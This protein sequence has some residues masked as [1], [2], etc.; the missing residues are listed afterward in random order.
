M[1]PNIAI[2]LRKYG[3]SP[4]VIGLSIGIPAILYAGMCPFVY[5]FTDR[6]QKRGVLVI[7]YI[8]ITIGC[9]L[10][11]SGNFLDFLNIN[12]HPI[13]IFIG[14]MLVGLSGALVSI[15]VLPEMIEVYESDPD[16]STLY[17]K[18]QVEILIS[19]IFVTCSS[20]G[21]I[22]GPVVAANL[23]EYY[24][25]Q[26]AQYIYCAILC[27]FIL[28]YFWLTGKWAIFGPADP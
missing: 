17:D 5:K 13:I 18:K 19:G 3:Y 9:F 2:E 21:E 15:P 27:L 10:I 7:G 1:A 26:A 16:L 28:S 6:M 12:H 14:L 24:S 8:L 11:G 23:T 25:F 22:M 4:V 20:A